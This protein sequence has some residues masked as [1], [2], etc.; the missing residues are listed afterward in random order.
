[1]AASMTTICRQQLGRIPSS[2]PGAPKEQSA[3]RSYVD[4]FARHANN[5]LHA[6]RVIDHLLE[7][8]TFFP[9]IS[10]IVTAC[11][12]IS[13]TDQAAVKVRTSCKYC[14][15]SGYR[16]VNGEHGL[17]AAYPCNHL[18]NT[19]GRMGLRMNP[20]VSRQ[21]AAELAQVP[22]RQ[23]EFLQLRAAGKISGFRRVSREEL[24]HVLATAGIGVEV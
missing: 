1:M 5:E 24:N 7:N 19:S 22:K 2:L 23:A 12:Q 6:I 20:T 18:D 16:V 14:Q 13:A 3:Q 15:G 21:Y 8:S 11:N 10:E 17:S 9:K 4:I